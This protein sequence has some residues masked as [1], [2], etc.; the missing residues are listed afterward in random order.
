MAAVLDR[1]DPLRV[2]A[3]APEQQIVEGAAFGVDCLLG[4]HTAGSFLEG[5]RGVRLLVGV[6]PDHDHLHRPFSLGI[7]R[8]RMPGGHISVGAMPAPYQVTPGILGRRRATLH[9]PVRPLVDRKSMSQPAA[10]PRTYRP[11]RTPPPDLPENGTEKIKGVGGWFRSDFAGSVGD[12]IGRGC[13][14]EGLRSRCCGSQMSRMVNREVAAPAFG[15]ASAC[16]RVWAGWRRAR[17]GVR[18]YVG[19][20]DDVAKCRRQGPLGLPRSLLLKGYLMRAPFVTL[21]PTLPACAACQ[22]RTVRA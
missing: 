11:R 22:S 20:G 21:A 10:S 1:P 12:R 7:S 19:A 5:S 16:R 15:H 6:R 3:P 2:Q 17:G 14:L 18:L 9:P 8:K 13:W 4:D